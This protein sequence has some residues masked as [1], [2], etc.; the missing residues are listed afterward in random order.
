MG[1][2]SR[3]K[4]DNP[5]RKERLRKA[6]VAYIRALR[7]AGKTLTVMQLLELR[8]DDAID[9]TAKV[10]WDSCSSVDM[11][12]QLVK[13]RVDRE[14]LGLVTDTNTVVLKGDGPKT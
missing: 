10:F 6:R 7:Q 3:R 1:K 2:A 14:I 5:W 12:E 11:L 9:S 13:A 4:R 8:F